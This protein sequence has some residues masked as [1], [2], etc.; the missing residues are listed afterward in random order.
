MKLAIVLA[1]VTVLGVQQTRDV[2]RYATGTAVLS[3][4]VVVD[5]PNGQPVRRA[6]VALAPSADPRAL[7]QV[8]SDDNGRFSFTGMPQGHVRITVSKPGFVTT[9]YG[10]RA[11]GATVGQPVALTNGQTTDIAVRLPR[12]AVISGTVTD[13]NGAP[14]GSVRVQAQ[15]VSVSALGERVFTPTSIVNLPTTDDRGAYR[16][17]GLAAGDYIVTA[18]PSVTLSRGEVRQTSATELQWADRQLRGGATGTAAAGREN[19]EA[20]APGRTVTYASVYYPGSVNAAAAGIVSVVAGQERSSVDL[21]MQFVP[22][23][24]VEGRVSR[25]DGQPARFQ[26]VILIPETAQALEQERLLAMMEVGLIGGG[27]TAT[28]TTADGS[29]SIQGVEPG[30][31]TVLARTA[32][33][34][35][36]AG[37]AAPSPAEGQWA[38]TDIRVDGQD[39]TGLDLRLAPGQY[40]SGRVLFET[41][42][43]PV[44]P[45]RVSLSVRAASTR[46]V[47]V[48][49]PALPL[50]EPNDAF[51]VVG[52]IPA[53]YRITATAPGWT[54]KSAMLGNRDVADV[55]FEIKPGADVPGLVLTLTDSPAEVS[56]TLFDG[57][58]R[59]TSDLSIVLFATDRAMW[60]AGSRRVRPA[61]RP[62]TDG[63]FIFT[64]LVAGEYYLAALG[65]VSP[66]ELAN[67]QFLEQVV[68]AAI[69]ITVG[70]GEKK[71]QDLRIAGAK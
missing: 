24:R 20:P 64:G 45:P 31:Y 33:A 51:T 32:V 36:G 44:T 47:G 60:F 54:L 46:G 71:T 15:R 70:H 43:R 29:F 39:I 26:S 19:A 58:N 6:L 61:V 17:Y 53:P 55:P 1:A 40:V 57:A 68:P 66:A 27:P 10:A 65:D 42:T 21:R 9:Y 12:G 8:A 59:P 34:A 48:S 30:S 14:M 5:E 50:L 11:P 4:T 56:G 13:E 23:A 35:R 2:V 38:M 37:A 22:T 69:K 7:Y 18:R 63:R 16:I 41:R 28:T 3:G 67:P 62:A 25:P 49:L 52:L